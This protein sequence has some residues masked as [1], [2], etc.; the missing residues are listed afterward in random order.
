VE[1]LAGQQRFLSEA[2]TLLVGSLDYTTTLQ[3]LTRLA[4]PALADWCAVDMLTEGGRV[5]RLE[6]AHKDPARV[7]LVRG[8]LRQQPIDL[9]ASAG[10]G[11]VLRTGESTWM[12]HVPEEALIAAARTP[13]TL[14]QLREI[15]LCSYL[16]VP[17]VARGRVLGCLTLAH[18]ESGRHYT[19]ADLRLV[20]E[21]A[22]RAALCVDNSRL[23]RESREAIR[24]RD[25][26]L[27][28]ASHELKTP[29][30]SLRLQLSLI[31]R[32]LGEES[33][34]RLGGRLDTAHRQVDRLSTLVDTLLDV[35]RIATGHIALAL[36]EVDLTLLVQEAMERLREV[37]AQ[38]GSTV[39]LQAPGAV[40]GHWD[41][42]RLDQVIVNL[43]TNAAKYGQGRPILVTVEATAE[44][45][46]L[47]VRDE[48][49][50]IAAEALPRLF[51]RFERAVSVRHY[52]GLGLGL[53]ISRQ[54]IDALG[55]RVRVDSRPDEGS[56]VTVELPRR[57]PS[58]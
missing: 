8:M 17:L 45:A 48:G 24:L 40:V 37:F 53:Y 16:C 12:S 43:L 22:R 39:T 18:A 7:E 54:I 35:S 50:G 2:S 32:L 20:E 29:L 51:G 4:V 33:R 19:E 6:V 41:A 1:V 34:Q 25:E 23:Y 27:S 15:G 13:E 56:T 3:S 14:R 52:G 11:R 9:S 55:G 42:L 26:F 30:T 58:R 47:T 21:L 38:A 46:R 28:I 57:G 44:L 10:A 5:E 31:E 36:A 49:I